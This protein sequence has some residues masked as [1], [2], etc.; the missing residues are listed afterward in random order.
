[1]LD[2]DYAYLYL[3]GHPDCDVFKYGISNNPR[4][5]LAH[6]KATRYGADMGF[7][8]EDAEILHHSERMPLPIA[9]QEEARWLTLN[10]PMHTLDGWQLREVVEGSFEGVLEKFSKFCVEASQAKPCWLTDEWLGSEFGVFNVFSSRDEKS[11]VRVYRSNRNPMIGVAEV[12]RKNSF[13]FHDATFWGALGYTDR[14][15]ES[16]SRRVVPKRGFYIVDV[17]ADELLN[18]YQNCVTGDIYT[19]PVRSD[20]QCDFRELRIYENTVC[21]GNHDEGREGEPD[22]PKSGQDFDDDFFL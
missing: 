1:M 7:P 10:L 11:P 13:L 6:L 9:I 19:R 21:D 16:V 2:D 14:Y 22:F 5:R 3:I 12:Y 8:I 18:N 15:L 4:R 17:T 20:M